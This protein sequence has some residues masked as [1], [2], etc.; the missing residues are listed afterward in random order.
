MTATAPATPRAASTGAAA[1]PTSTPPLPGFTGV[2]RIPT[3]VNEPI[4]SYAPGSSERAELKAR[5]ASMSGERPDIP[6]VIGGQEIRTGQTHQV[7]MPH[8]HQHVLAD[9][10]HVTPAHAEQAIARALEA[11]AS[12]ANWSWEDRCAVFLRAADLL[13]GP[14]RATINAATMLGQSK[15]VYQA[16]IDA[17]CEMA[18]FFRFNAMYAQQI[19]EEQPLSVPGAWK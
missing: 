10:H 17:A 7:T 19:Y 6:A 9:F 15:N 12:W 8:A 18:D 13:T 16:E 1:T 2:R 5:L 4:K 14:W 11:R 3:A